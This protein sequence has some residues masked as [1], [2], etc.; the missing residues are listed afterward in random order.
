MPSLW[1]WGTLENNNTGCHNVLLC[2]RLNIQVLVLYRLL[3]L[4]VQCQPHS[5]IDTGLLRRLVY[6]IIQE[7]NNYLISRGS[8]GAILSSGPL[9]G[10]RGKGQI[11]IVRQEPFK[12]FLNLPTTTMN[13]PKV[14][15]QPTNLELGQ[16]VHPDYQVCAYVEITVCA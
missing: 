15:F 11:K 4:H 16:C 9:Q 5:I 13:F 7:S 12:H 3:R 6:S 2:T 1:S 14:V 8:W 10:G